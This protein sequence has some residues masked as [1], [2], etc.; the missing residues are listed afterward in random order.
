[1]F[2]NGRHRTILLT[3]F[4]DDIPLAIC[5]TIK[6]HSEI[7]RAIIRKIEEDDFIEFP[8]LPIKSFAELR[9]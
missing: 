2:H 9:V 5:N 1:M 6:E 4:R 8:D 7:K 3:Q